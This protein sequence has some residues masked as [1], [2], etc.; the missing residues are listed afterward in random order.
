MQS[1]DVVIIGAGPGGYVA[2]IRAAQLGFQVALIEKNATLGGTCLNVGCVP[3]KAMLESSELFAKLQ[4]GLDVHGIS[5]K[6]PKFNLPTL[7]GRKDKVVKD[8]VDGLSLLM[9]KN[10]ITVIQGRA[11]LSAAK[12]VVVETETE[13]PTEPLTL[14]AKHIILATGSAPVELPFLKFDGKRVVS[15][16]EALAFS[17][18]PKKL[19]VIGAGAV[20]LEL[21]SVWQRLG[22]EVT[23]I[24]MLPQITPF[25]D[26][27]MARTLERSLKAQGINILTKTQLTGAEPIK[28]GLR[29]HYTDAKGQAQ[30]LDC[31]KVLCAVGR[32]PVTADLGLKE[33]GIELDQ[34]GFVV[35]NDQFAT[36]V[37]GIYAIGDI[38]RGPMLAH[39]A[40]EEGVAVAEI[41]AGKPGHVGYDEIPCVVYTWPELAQVGL[42]EEQCKE[43]KREI[44]V[45]RYYFKANARAKSMDEEDGLVK[46]IAD[47]STDQ[48]LGV[49]IVGPRA[50]DMIAEVVVAMAFKGSAEDLGRIVHAHPTLGEIIKEAALAVDRRAIHG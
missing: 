32:K 31:D 41:L 45:G 48:L 26:T 39:K 20:G 33:I 7:L 44:K 43:Q 13:T 14:E 40:Q 24:E 37:P 1:F 18:V 10:K 4:H 8:V 29:L 11:R 19:V 15:S 9:K 47:A 28:A 22:A 2:A 49:H 17:K 3:S 36:N 12:Q 46:V 23:V 16:T 6:T 30:Q 50:S 25:A 27:Q 42:T 35:I 5:V 34:R 38:V 21:G